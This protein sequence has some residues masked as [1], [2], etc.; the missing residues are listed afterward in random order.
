MQDSNRQIEYLVASLIDFFRDPKREERYFEAAKIALN[1]VNRGLNIKTNLEKRFLFLASRLKNNINP[2]SIRTFAKDCL[3]FSNTPVPPKI[4]QQKLY[5][6]A[7]KE[8]ALAIALG[9]SE[10][11]ALN[12]AA[13]KL[14]KEKSRAELLEKKTIMAETHPLNLVLSALNSLD[15][16]VAKEDIRNHFLNLKRTVDNSSKDG[17]LFSLLKKAES[18]S[19]AKIHALLGDELFFLCK[20]LGFIDKNDQTLLIEVP[21]NAHLHALTYRKLDIILSLKKDANFSSVKN[22]KFK[23][24]SVF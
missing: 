4:D 2:L 18:F 23:V 9:H 20:P 14:I 11:M 12:M 22:I 7:K 24:I 3:N 16:K 8:V 17:K 21:T 1:Q 6:R 13:N 10:E 19:P 5:K 15:K